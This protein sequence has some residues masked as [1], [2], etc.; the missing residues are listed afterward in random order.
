LIVLKLSKAYIKKQFAS[1][2]VKQETRID[3]V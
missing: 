2:A 1:L 3:I